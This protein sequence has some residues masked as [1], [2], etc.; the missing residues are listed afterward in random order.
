M[1]DDQNTDKEGLKGDWK[2]G[3]PPAT[4]KF[5]QNTTDFDL[6]ANKITGESYIFHG[7]PLPHS[8]ERLEYDDR[9]K[10][11][12][13]IT[14]DGEILDLGVK[15]QWLIRPYFKREQDILVVQTKDGNSIDGVE[16]PLTVRETKPQE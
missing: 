3:S 10:R 14:K 5:F 2:S 1:S 15:L 6:Y 7:P 8:I 11:I 16:V 4:G 12:Y 9:D 13:V